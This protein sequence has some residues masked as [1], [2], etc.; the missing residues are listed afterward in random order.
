MDI[1]VV[2]VEREDDTQ[3]SVYGTS[4]IM[5]DNKYVIITANVVLPLF[6]DYCHEDVLLFDPGAIYSS[7]SLKEPINLKIILNQ[8]PE[9]PY[10][11]KNGNLFAFFSSKNIK[12]TAQEILQEWAIDT[13]ENSKELET[14]L[15][16]FFV[17]KI[18]PDNNILNLKKCLIQWWNLIKNEKM[19]QCEEILIR[20]VP[21]G[22][23]F[24]LNSYSRGII[25]NIV[26]HNSC[27]ILSDCPSS[28]GSE[29]SPVY[30]IDR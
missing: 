24:F 4:G 17:I 30:K 27:L 13:Q 2:A 6:T 23:K 3:K 7:F 29:G 10:Y 9:K 28:P 18:I 21:F 15:S 22:N 16:L 20:S 1:K 25:S 11:V 8:S 12:L 19:N 26:G 5:L 14:T